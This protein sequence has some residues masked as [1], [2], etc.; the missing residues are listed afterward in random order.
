MTVKELI[1]KLLEML[2]EAKV[3]AIYKTAFSATFID[4]NIVEM[5]IF[6]TNLVTLS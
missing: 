4:I 3:E 5:N 2:Q 1:A 6:N